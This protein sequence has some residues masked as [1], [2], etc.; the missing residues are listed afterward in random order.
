MRR[1][2]QVFGGKVAA[3]TD[4][5]RNQVRASQRTPPKKQGHISVSDK[6]KGKVWGTNSGK[7]KG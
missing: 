5:E 3:K 2:A 4:R 1:D 6:M 7:N